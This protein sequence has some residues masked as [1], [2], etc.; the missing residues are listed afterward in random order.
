MPYQPNHV[1]KGVVTK[2]GAMRKTATVTV[3]RIFEHPKILKEIKRHKKFL[4]HD[5]EELARLGDKVSIIHGTRTS[6]HKS[7]RLQSILS[8]NT[9]KFPDDPIPAEIPLPSIKPS[10]QKKLLEKAA[11]RSSRQVDASGG[12]GKVID[13]L[14]EAQLAKEQAAKAAEVAGRNVV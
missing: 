14:K 2:V 10:K 12:S 1:F 9:Q 4:V 11:L 13:A 8:R 7:F 6:R 5:E 3:E